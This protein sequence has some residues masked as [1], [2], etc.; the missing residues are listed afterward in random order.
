MRGERIYEGITSGLN[1]GAIER[2]RLFVNREFVGWNELLNNNNSDVPKGLIREM[3]KSA[4][5]R[6]FEYDKYTNKQLLD[7]LQNAFNDIQKLEEEYCGDFK[8][9]VPKILEKYP[10]IGH[11]LSGLFEDVSIVQDHNNWPHSLA[12]IITA[13]RG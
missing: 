10:N 11:L 3:H 1:T 2:A 5:D 4:G 13:S 12:A 6:K 8:I 9:F 7:Y